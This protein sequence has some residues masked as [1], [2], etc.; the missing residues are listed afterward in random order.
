M[1]GRTPVVHRI[2]FNPTR[3]RVVLGKLLLREAA[4]SV[5]AIE[6]DGTGRRPA[7][8]ESQHKVSHAFV[9]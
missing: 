7:L 3:L 4:D 1:D 2:V 8:V 6:H 9:L 5:R